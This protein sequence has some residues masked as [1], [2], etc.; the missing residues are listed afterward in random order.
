MKFIQ[1]HLID[2]T[3]L[4]GVI[5]ISIGCFIFNL[6]AGFIITGIMLT[7]GAYIMSRGGV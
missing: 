2:I 5:L 7:A 4:V 1:R 6:V 3:A